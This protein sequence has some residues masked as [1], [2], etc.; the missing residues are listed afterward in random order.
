MVHQGL[1]LA[2]RLRLQKNS[3]GAHQEGCVFG[4]LQ[5]FLH[6]RPGNFHIVVNQLFP[7][8]Y[9]GALIDR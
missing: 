5:A 3:V 1:C 9:F 7:A 8:F 2:E 6:G 4:S